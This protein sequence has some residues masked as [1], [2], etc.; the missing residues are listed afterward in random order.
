MEKLSLT[1]ENSFYRKLLL[2]M[3]F[4]DSFDYRKDYHT[5]VHNI[6]QDYIASI[7]ISRIVY[8]YKTFRGFSGALRRQS[9]TFAKGPFKGKVF[10]AKHLLRM[11]EYYSII[12]K[13]ANLD[14]YISLYAYLYRIYECLI[15]TGRNLA[16]SFYKAGLDFKMEKGADDRYTIFVSRDYE[17]FR[18]TLGV[19]RFTNMETNFLPNDVKIIKRLI[20]IS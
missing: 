18:A 11:E 16:Y 15:R 8:G 5:F 14:S 13:N 6:P 2:Y 10:S 20:N 1:V 4:Y 7:L 17:Y 12:L 9:G 3:L 19:L